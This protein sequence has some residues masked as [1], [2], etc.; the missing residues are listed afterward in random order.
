MENFCHRATDHTSYL[1]SPLPGT[2]WRKAY[3]SI[4]SELVFDKYLKLHSDTILQID[5]PSVVDVLRV[6]YSFKS[7]NGF[8]HQTEPLPKDT[9]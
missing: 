2:S 3:Y 9:I 1:P 8:L 7:M 5:L 6:W 4:V